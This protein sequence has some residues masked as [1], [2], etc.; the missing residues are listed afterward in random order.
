MNVEDL[1]FAEFCFRY[2]DK[3]TVSLSYHVI[4]YK[5]KQ[6]TLEPRGQVMQY[7]IPLYGNVEGELDPK[8]IGSVAKLNFLN[9]K[10]QYD[11]L[12]DSCFC[13]FPSFTFVPSNDIFSFLAGISLPRS[14]VSSILIAPLKHFLYRQL[15]IGKYRRNVLKL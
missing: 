7:L 12:D 3:I 13:C 1:H 15:A 14:D 4:P 10:I 6:Y 11:P 9:E 8:S 5:E 2:L